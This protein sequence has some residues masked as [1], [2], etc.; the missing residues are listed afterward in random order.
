MSTAYNLQFDLSQQPYHFDGWLLLLPV[1]PVAVLLASIAL[2]W[3]SRLRDRYFGSSEGRPFR[4][5]FVIFFSGI[6]SV[7]TIVA[8]AGTLEHARFV[9]ARYS[10]G[11]I[12]STSGCMTSF[13]PWLGGKNDDEK[14]SLNNMC[15][16]YSDNV[17]MPGFRHGVARG[18]PVRA[19]SRLRIYYI[20]NDIVRL[21]TIGH[22]C[23]A[24]PDDK[25]ASCLGQ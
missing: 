1:V 15:F 9:Y 3:N 11:N 12:P 8:T 22:A 4:L 18:G 2:A 5:L 21:E 24:A 6:M 20:G 13:H 25:S 14:I 17:M 16:N 7:G 10:R 23:P 19:D